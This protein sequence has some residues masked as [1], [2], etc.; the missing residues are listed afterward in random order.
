M[1]PVPAP[2]FQGCSSKYQDR[3]RLEESD[4]EWERERERHRERGNREG[5]REGGRERGRERDSGKEID[6]ALSR[7]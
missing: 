1:A 5:G 6:V 4:R 2:A 3:K 7:P